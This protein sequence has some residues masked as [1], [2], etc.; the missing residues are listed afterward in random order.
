MRRKLITG[1]ILTIAAVVAA[2][3]AGSA[4]SASAENGHRVYLA[5]NGKAASSAAVEPGSAPVSRD[6]SLAL[7]GMTWASWA[8]RA[9]GTGTATVN[10]CDPDCATGTA[11]KVPV[12]VT[13]SAPQEMCG[14]EFYTDMRLA[15]T[16]PLPDGLPAATSVPVAPFC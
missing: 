7:S 13:L 2:A 14:R 12:T 6:S 4:L 11:V 9:T 3:P 16:G 15:F 5:A 8:D 1:S 10:L